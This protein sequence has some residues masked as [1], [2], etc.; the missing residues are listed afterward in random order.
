[1][2][3]RRVDVNNLLVKAYPSDM[4]WQTTAEAI[5]VHGGYGFTEE[6][7]VAHNVPG[8]LKFHLSGKA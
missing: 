4:V 7:L 8:T 2:A 1:M 6:Y 5:Q 3:E